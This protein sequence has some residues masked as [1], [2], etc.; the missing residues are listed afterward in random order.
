MPAGKW[1]GEHLL[2]SHAD[3]TPKSLSARSS[4]DAPTA[5]VANHD[6]LASWA[7][8]GL[9]ASDVAVPG[10]VAI[11]G[12]DDGVLADGLGLTTVRQPFEESGRVALDLLLGMFADDS[13]PVR[14][15]DLMP[16][17]VVRSST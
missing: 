2:P 9:A 4:L 10:D 8:R 5:V 6:E 7:W 16:S 14:R 17:L 12:F 13:G 11:L 15:V 1:D 3:P